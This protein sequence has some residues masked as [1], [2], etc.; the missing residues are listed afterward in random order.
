M[1]S[2]MSCS[3]PTQLVQPY[4]DDKY[5]TRTNL[6]HKGSEVHW[7]NHLKRKILPIGTH[8]KVLDI[9]PGYCKIEDEQG[10]GYELLFPGE[11][12]DDAQKAISFYLSRKNPM[13]KIK[14][15]PEEI[16]RKIM[17]GEAQTSMTKEQVLMALGYPP[18]AFDSYIYL[19]LNS[20]EYIEEEGHDTQGEVKKKIL[21][22]KASISSNTL[23]MI[24][25]SEEDFFKLKDYNNLDPAEMEIIIKNK[26][27][28]VEKSLVQRPSQ[29][30]TPIREAR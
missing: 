17:K 19:D 8:V 20:W 9:Y 4:K 22:F 5:W 14:H 6:R 3:F 10:N 24:K 11:S 12:F 7:D 23:V 21:D 27:K 16:R 28:G 13:G 2:L 15:F 1:L 18:L 25:S 30:G 29:R 26:L